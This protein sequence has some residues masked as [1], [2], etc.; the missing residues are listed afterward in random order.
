MFRSYR[1]FWIWRR[2]GSWRSWRI[3]RRIHPPLVA[4]VF[5]VF[6][7]LNSQ[8]MLDRS[9]FSCG[10]LLDCHVWANCLM[11]YIS[12]CD[13]SGSQFEFVLVN[14]ESSSLLFQWPCLYMFLVV[15]FDRTC[16]WRHVSL[17]GNDNGS[18]RQSLRWWCFP[19]YHSF[20]SWLPFQTS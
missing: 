6:F 1:G 9:R 14:K 13:F 7:C 16:R 17:A 10:L 12:F 19:C 2:S 4:Q 18:F 5:I 3:C 8:I 15:F 11:I 20:P